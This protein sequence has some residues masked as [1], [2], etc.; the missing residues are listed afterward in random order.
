VRADARSAKQRWWC[1]RQAGT[2][3][4]HSAA[5]HGW[6]RQRQ[7][8]LPPW[9]CPRLCTHT[10][11]E[12]TVTQ[13]GKEVN[14]LFKADFF[15][16]KA[17]LSNEPRGATVTTVQETVCLVLDRDTFVEILGP[18]DKAM[19]VRMFGGGG[20]GLCLQRCGVAAHDHAQA[21]RA[22]SLPQESSA[23][24]TPPLL[25]ACCAQEA[26]SETVSQQ[27]MALWQPRGSAAAAARPRAT[28]LLS[29]K[30]GNGFKQVMVVCAQ[31]MQLAVWCVAGGAVWLGQQTSPSRPLPHHHTPGGR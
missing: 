19:A 24:H 30:T 13:G 4:P 23:T 17:L 12:A 5:C 2:H 29:V 28:V 8:S 6:R 21:R 18:L 11:G 1:V 3:G 31:R 26:K 9:T 10:S 16:E 15:G 7:G 20:A 27:R 14:R 22:A 25:A